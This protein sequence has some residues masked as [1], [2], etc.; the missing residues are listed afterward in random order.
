[1]PPKS[2]TGK[3]RVARKPRKYAKKSVVPRLVQSNSQFAQ[4]SETYNKGVL[5]AN[6]AVSVIIGGLDGNLRAQAV[7][8]QYQLYR[9][10]KVEIK[11]KPLYDTYIP[12]AAPTVGPLTVPEFYYSIVRDGDYPTAPTTVYFERRGCKPKRLD[13]KIVNIDYK[14]NALLEVSGGT[15]QINNGQVKMTPWLSCDSQQG[16]AW[17]PNL[18]PHHGVVF[19]AFCT[20]NPPAVDTVPIM[21]VSITIHYQFKKPHQQLEGNDGFTCE[22]I[23]PTGYQEQF[24]ASGNSLD[25]HTHSPSMH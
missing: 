20:T 3:G 16:I 15:F 22:N 9:I 24:D 2:K 18:T 8:R 11:C 7:A 19:G 6:K 10:S 13:D 1:M 12:G 4:M 17:S 23:A 21:T 25:G 14:P 5:Y